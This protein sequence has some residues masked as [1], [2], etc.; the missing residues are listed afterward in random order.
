[1]AFMLISIQKGCV[2]RIYEGVDLLYRTAVKTTAWRIRITQLEL[3]V[4]NLIT[5]HFCT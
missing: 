4:I 3:A 5:K 2:I 1:M